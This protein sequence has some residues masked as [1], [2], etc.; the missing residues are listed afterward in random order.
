VSAES[1]FGFGLLGPPRLGGRPGLS[2]IRPSLLV[3]EYPTPGD[4]AWLVEEHGITV[5]VSLQ[6]DADLAA[7]GLTA[8]A[9]ERLRGV[10]AASRVPVPDGDER[11]R[12]APRRDRGPARPLVTAASAFITAT[13]VNRAPGPPSPLHVN[14]AVEAAATP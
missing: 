14:E 1:P 7:K 8:A 2:E 4:A 11:A 6:E 13:P 12:R 9:L 10:R 3:G 5:V